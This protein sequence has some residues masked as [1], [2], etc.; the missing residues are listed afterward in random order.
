MTDKL[1]AW[2]VGDEDW[3]E[4]L[5]AETRGKARSLTVGLFSDV[6][7]SDNY[8]YIRAIRFPAADGRAFTLAD[9]WEVDGEGEHDE[10][11]I[12][13]CGCVR[14]NPKPMEVSNE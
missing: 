8:L 7:I 2:I 10:K 12:S 4:L 1:K 3:L 9:R 14:C 5:H 6:R 11:Y 13:E